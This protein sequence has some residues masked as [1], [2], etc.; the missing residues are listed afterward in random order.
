MIRS[1]MRVPDRACTSRLIIIR[2]GRAG[3]FTIAVSVTVGLHLF[4]PFI[5]ASSQ[6]KHR[7]E[8]ASAETKEL[9]GSSRIERK[10]YLEKQRVSI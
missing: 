5:A 2:A 8:L 6:D 9:G 10:T 7:D 1:C 3:A 4:A